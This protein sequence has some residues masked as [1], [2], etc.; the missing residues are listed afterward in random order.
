MARR[1]RPVFPEH[2]FPSVETDSMA[3]LYPGG[4]GPYA[5]GAAM[6]STAR[7]RRNRDSTAAS[8]ALL[9]N[10]FTYNNNVSGAAETHALGPRVDWKQ[11]PSKGRSWLIYLNQLNSLAVLGGDYVETGQDRY[12]A[13]VGELVLSWVDQC[14]ADFE[15]R[16]QARNRGANCLAAYEAVRK[17]P[18]FS[19][20]AHAAVLRLLALTCRFLA[21]EPEG[22]S[23]VTYSGL[24]PMAVML[25][26]FKESRAWLKAG[27]DNL[28]AINF[29]RTTPDGA[30]DGHSI[31]YHGVPI[32][33]GARA[34]EFLEANADTPEIVRLAQE[35][36]AQNARM[37]AQI[38]WLVLPNG[39]IPNL[40]DIYGRCDWDTRYRDQYARWCLEYVPP[41][42]KA[43]L[44][45]I[46]DP[47]KRTLALLAQLEGTDGDQPRRTS[48]GF[49][50]AGYY[51]MRS[52][53]EPEE[54]RCLYFDLS[55]QARSHAHF[56]L[57]SFELHAYG[58]P[59]LCDTGDYFLGY[60]ERTKLHNGVEVDGQSQSWGDRS[61]PYEWTTTEA[62]D[63]VDG[64]ST[65]FQNQGCRHRRKVI[66]LKPDY[67][68]MS[69]LLTGN[70]EHLA[71]Q[72]FHFAPVDLTRATTVDTDAAAKTC[73]TRSPDRANILIA[74][75][76]PDRVDLRFAERPPFNEP[77]KPPQD[78]S[79]LGWFVSA[80]FQKFESPV[81]VYSRRAA[82]PFAMDTVLF[83]VPAH[84][85][86]SVKVVRLPVLQEGHPVGSHQA[87]ALQVEVHVTGPGKDGQRYR[88]MVLISHDGPHR[89]QYGAYT[90]DGELAWLRFQADGRLAR[91]A[92]KN[93]RALS[94]GDRVLARSETEIPD[95]AAVWQADTVRLAGS[96]V[97]G[98]ELAANG[99]SR[100]IADIGAV[101]SSLRGKLLAT[102][103]S[104]ERA[105]LKITA[106]TAEAVPPQ[107]GL[108]GAQPGILVTWRT[109][110]P[111]SAR[112]L[113]LDPAGDLH[114]SF[115]TRAESA[116]HRVELPNLLPG[117]TYR[118]RALAWDRF[119]NLV[120]SGEV[121]VKCK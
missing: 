31:D 96:K 118:L 39:G 109:D 53:W 41:K 77:P 97:W 85:G 3:L 120:E 11:N 110:R 79:L 102:A 59:L 37:V 12:A 23:G 47:W 117:T 66:F 100:A 17:S 70:G 98:L 21:G 83:P 113:Y 91:L 92:I 57:C 78:E 74:P 121:E 27:T 7:I 26:E 10:T 51:V 67:W 101:Q 25:P 104:P 88:D 107:Q 55:S 34:L 40:G 72:Y 19:P 95:V 69:D 106:L 28:L 5:E 24:I 4:P 105:P 86:A 18:A 14:P 8:D 43:R 46:G 42:T 63:L 36:R 15:G 38:L 35:V 49:S 20:E 32:Q 103:P 84:A 45:A 115:A 52:G 9:Q 2:R 94:G 13:K 56:D 22:G 87:S 75:A 111:A 80:V 93:G 116:D 108:A 6:A 71:E 68:V 60:S 81:A 16:M 61:I 73:L 65:S 82:L 112:V 119:G 54:A 30:R 76:D 44:E 29:Q 33:W 48:V 90:F 50:H 62:F 58:K 99:A 1:T 114:R 64:A 89:R